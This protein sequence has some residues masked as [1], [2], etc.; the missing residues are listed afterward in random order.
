M[1]LLQKKGIA[2]KRMATSITYR[3]QHR[4]AFFLIA[5]VINLIMLLQE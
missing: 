5:L 4:I 3:T 2:F 1:G